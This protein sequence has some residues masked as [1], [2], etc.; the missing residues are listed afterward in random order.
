MT[1]PRSAY[2][3]PIYACQ[4]C[5]HGESELTIRNKVLT[6]C[7]KCGGTM[8]EVGIPKTDAPS[9][10]DL[11]CFVCARMKQWGIWDEVSGVAV[12]VE[13][14]DKARAPERAP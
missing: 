8:R 3:F 9:P 14:R 5:W 10:C 13:C 6:A 2:A 7:P 11:L 12:C 1:P 4:D